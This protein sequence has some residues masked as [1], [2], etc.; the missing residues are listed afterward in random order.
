MILS[1]WHI[2][3]ILLFLELIFLYLLLI[4]NLKWTKDYFETSLTFMI[5][6]ALSYQNTVRKKN[7]INRRDACLS[8]NSCLFTYHSRNIYKMP[9]FYDTTFHG[10]RKTMPI[11]VNRSKQRYR[12]HSLVLRTPKLIHIRWPIYGILLSWHSVSIHLSHF[13]I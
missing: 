11:F 6:Y 12:A 13:V 7:R 2:L 1:A 3:I 8:S 4:N 5:Q 10:M 9:I